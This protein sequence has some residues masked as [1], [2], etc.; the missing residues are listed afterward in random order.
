MIADR[1]EDATV[2]D[3]ATGTVPSGIAENGHTGSTTVTAGQDPFEGEIAAFRMYESVLSD[4]E[5]Q[6]NYDAT[7]LVVAAYDATSVAGAAVTVNADG[8]FTY[9]PGSLAAS[10]VYFWRIVAS[11]DR[12][13]S[14]IGP[15]WSFTTGGRVDSPPTIW[16]GRALFGSA[17]GHVYCVRAS[18]GKLVWRFF[19]VADPDGYQ[20]EV[21]ERSGRVK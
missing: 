17:D 10:T 20:I 9:D 3:W 18:D 2:N 19:F 7:R 5:A 4:A 11:D 12:G 1:V 6:A 14:S 16:K 21:L 15:V 13:G 8:G